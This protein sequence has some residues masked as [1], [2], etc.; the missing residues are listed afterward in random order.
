MR[1][2]T[3]I[4]W[5]AAAVLIALALLAAWSGQIPPRQPAS[6][7]SVSLGLLL[8]DAEEGVYI[9]AVSDGSAADAAG[10]LPG[11]RILAA[12]GMTLG[13]ALALNERLLTAPESLLL[14]VRRDGE[15]LILPLR[16]R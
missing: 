16:C 7:D 11:D 2:K 4:W 13:S 14:T 5:L 12:D 1:T 10:F 3:W 8:L 15:E 6:A 9:L